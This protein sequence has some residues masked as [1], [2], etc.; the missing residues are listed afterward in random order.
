MF[1]E[2][3]HLHVADSYQLEGLS[4]MQ[5]PELRAFTLNSLRFS[6][7]E[8]AQTMAQRLGEAELPKIERYAVRLT[9]TWFANIALEDN[10]YL[11]VYSERYVE[12]EDGDEDGD[13]GDEP[14]A[15]R[16]DEADEGEPGGV[17]WNVLDEL[18]Q[19]LA[20]SPLRQLAL[21]AFHESR[22]LLESLARSGLPAKLEELDL[23]DSDLDDSDATWMASNPKQFARLKRLVVRNTRLGERGAQTLAKL[24]PEVVYTPGRGVSHR[25]VVGQE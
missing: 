20:K 21:T 7:W 10:P 19:V 6:D 23:S 15:D 14:R 2:E 12:D 5:A 4:P 18:L 22:S 16:Y 3:L 11:P 9:E 13:E 8:D 24:G 1:A 17:N 25:Y